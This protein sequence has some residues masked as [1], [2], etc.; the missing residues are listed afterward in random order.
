MSDKTR[1]S[2]LIYLISL[3]IVYI[4]TDSLDSPPFYIYGREEQLLNVNQ[5]AKLV[6]ILSAKTI[7]NEILIEPF[8]ERTIDPVTGTSYGLSH[9]GYDVRVRET[10]KILAGEFRLGSLIEHITMTANVVGIVH[11]KSTWARRGIAVQNTV[12]EPGWRGFLTVEVSFHGVGRI[13]IPAGSPIAQILFH[14]VDADCEPYRGK[15][16]DQPARPVSA[17]RES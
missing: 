8:N 13:T 15:Y 17:L 10:L 7:R 4:Y 2:V 6:M 14:R 16:Q 9:C 1:E 12:I 11:D 3:Y 5:G